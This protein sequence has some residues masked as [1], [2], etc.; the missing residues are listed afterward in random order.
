MPNFKPC[1]CSQ[2]PNAFTF[3]NFS[4]G[5]MLPS[6]ARCGDSQPS[7][8]FMYVHP[9]SIKS[10]SI[11][12]CAELFTLA[13]LTLKP[14]QF[15]L[16]QPIA[17]VRAIKSPTLIIKSLLSVPLLLET[18][19]CI[20]YSPAAG[21]DPDMMPVFSSTYNPCGK[22]SIAYVNGFSPVAAILYRK[23]EAG[24]TPT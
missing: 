8:I 14:Q 24:L 13:S 18:T 16:F 23:G 20:L 9:W 5:T 2:S 15:Q 11:S 10:L 19:N 7:S 3:G 4:L 6:G 12:A 21:K 1:A 22:F 17:G